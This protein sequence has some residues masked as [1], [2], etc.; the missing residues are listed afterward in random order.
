MELVKRKIRSAGRTSGSVE[1]TLP[2]AMQVLEGIACNIALRDGIEPEIIVQPEL[3]VAQGL[4]IELWR[5]LH[6]GLEAAGDMGDFSLTDFNVGLFPPRHWYQRP[7]LSYEDALNIL[8]YFEQ[9]LPSERVQKSAPLQR[10]ITFLAIDAAYRLGLK[11]PLAVAFGDAVGYLATGINGIH[12]SEFEQE[13]A[14]DAYGRGEPLTAGQ[15][16]SLSIDSEWQAAQDGLRCVYDLFLEWQE[17]PGEYGA[18]KERWW[19]Q[20]IRVEAG[21]SISTVEAYLRRR[22]FKP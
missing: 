7:P 18:A 13:G 2:V 1:I 19:R 5:V 9:N 10:L 16:K 22:T 11:G 3:S 8:S 21:T 4:F 6:V 14:L 20:R 12:G 15:I 17:R